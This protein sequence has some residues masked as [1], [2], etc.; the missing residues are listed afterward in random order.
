MKK[1]LYIMGIEW[2]WIFQRP[3][4]LARQLQDM[5]EVTVVCPKQLIHPKHQNNEP[6]DRLIELLQIPFQEKLQMIGKVANSC[7]L[8]AVSA[9]SLL[10]TKFFVFE[11][12]AQNLCHIQLMFISIHNY[13]KLSSSATRCVNTFD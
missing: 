3:H 2:N 8:D 1:M 12:Q 6:P 4:I 9:I 11:N 5:Y 7:K 10:L 13:F